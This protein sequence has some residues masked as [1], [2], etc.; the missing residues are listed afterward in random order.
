[1]LAHVARRSSCLAHRPTTTA[2][3]LGRRALAVK[4]LEEESEFATITAA[5]SLSVVYFTASWCGP[6]KMI[7]PIFEKVSEEHPTTSFLKVDVD[8]QAEVAAMCQISAMPTFQ[9]Y[10][11]GKVIDKIVGADAEKLISYVKAHSE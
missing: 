7:S 6:C 2:L 11:S 9:F 3:G 4:V 8:D 5:E 1:M 10:K